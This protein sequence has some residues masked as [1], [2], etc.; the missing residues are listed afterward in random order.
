MQAGPGFRSRF[1]CNCAVDPGAIRAPTPHSRR[2][3]NG[4]RRSGRA[5][6]ST[7]GN[8][9][10]VNDGAA[11]LIIASEAAAKS[12]ASPRL[13]AC[14][15]VPRNRKP[16]VKVMKIVPALSHQIALVRMPGQSLSPASS[17]QCS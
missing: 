3:K 2:S 12:T 5:A 1:F 17:V 15:A 16:H 4:R 13:P 6:R 14:S 10:G 7:P 8:S 9:S 11:A